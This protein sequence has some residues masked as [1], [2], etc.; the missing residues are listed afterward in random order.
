MGAVSDETTP[1]KRKPGRYEK[2]V[3]DL[4]ADYQ[5]PRVKLDPGNG[6]F[7][8]RTLLK[9]AQWAADNQPVKV[10]DVVDLDPAK[11]ESIDRSSG[12]WP[13]KEEMLDGPFTVEAVDYNGARDFWFF[14]VRCGGGLFNVPMDWVRSFWRPEVEE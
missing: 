8:L 11:I 1:E 2:L 7:H 3:D 6:E 5:A 10:G 4:V 13:W 9:I 12:W 14:A